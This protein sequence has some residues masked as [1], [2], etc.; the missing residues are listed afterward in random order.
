M[1]RGQAAPDDDGDGAEWIVPGVG[2]NAQDSS[3]LQP[4]GISPWRTPAVLRQSREVRVKALMRAARGLAVCGVDVKVISWVATHLLLPL[5]LAFCDLG[6]RRTFTIAL[7]LAPVSVADTISASASA[8]AGLDG[9]QDTTAANSVRSGSSRAEVQ[10]GCGGGAWTCAERWQVACFFA[11]LATSLGLYYSLYASDPG[12]ITAAS[13]APATEPGAPACQQCGEVPSARCHHDKH[14]GSCVHKHDHHCWFLS[15]SI[16]DRNHARFY[17]LLVVEAVLLLWMEFHVVQLWAR[18]YLLRPP[19][20]RLVGAWQGRP[21]APLLAQLPCPGVQG[22]L[23]LG[24]ACALGI[25]GAVW[26]ALVVYLLLLHSYLAATGQTTLELL[27]GHRLPYLM[28][29]YAA[30]QPHQLVAGRPPSMLD[31]AGK[32]VS[33]LAIARQHLRGTPPPRPFDEGLMRNLY[34]FFL[35]PKPYPY[36]QKREAAAGDVEMH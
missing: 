12:W 30:L 31:G 17:L 29:S 25:F 6:V 16:G 2:T 15:A 26:L 21:Q 4:H 9:T 34:V 5:L 13:P 35:A 32:G 1:L 3:Q 20:M 14:T 33:L 23:G 24:M 36:R 19:L 22:T 28:R 10:V 27:K 7:A 11:L 18:C 8:V